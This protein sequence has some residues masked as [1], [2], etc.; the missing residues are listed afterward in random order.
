MTP[1][2]LNT[3]TDQE[4]LVRAKKMKSTS[5]INAVL[6]GV[7]IGI[8]IYSTIKKGFGFYTFFPLI[9]AFF[10]FNDSKKNKELKKVLQERN[11]I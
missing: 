6:F 2:N 4:L 11:L 9:F 3:L 10:A 5:I 7:M 1:E 8:A